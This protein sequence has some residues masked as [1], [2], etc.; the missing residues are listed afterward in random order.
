MCSWRGAA[1]GVR[2]TACSGRADA[3]A[4][5][6]AGARRRFARRPC[7]PIDHAS[8]ADPTSDPEHGGSAGW[9]R[10]AGGS[11]TAATP[12]TP[13]TIR[14]AVRHAGRA[15]GRVRSGERCCRARPPPCAV[16][17]GR[18][19]GRV[20][21]RASGSSAH[22]GRHRGR[23]RHVGDRRRCRHIAV[24]RAPERSA[25]GSHRP[26]GNP[27]SC[28]TPFRRPG[29]RPTLTHPPPAARTRWCP[30][31][32]TDRPHGVVAA[33]SE[34]SAAGRSMSTR[35]VPSVPSV[36]NTVSAWP[37]ACCRPTSEC[38]PHPES[39]VTTIES[40]GE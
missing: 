18:R 12:A 24:V 5:R 23:G 3:A 17:G 26:R 29:P 34:R 16:P 33:A 28:P 9:L 7:A 13:D 35:S 14:A 4:Q 20:L 31:E 11:G 1:G 40:R 19:A 32:P 8:V 6:R 21:R 25:R 15:A 22:R 30:A 38:A 36:L 2:P 37:R 10:W 39:R 27:V